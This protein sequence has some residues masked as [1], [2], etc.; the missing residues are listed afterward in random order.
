MVDSDER[1]ESDDESSGIEDLSGNK[2]TSGDE[3][4]LLDEHRNF[5]LSIDDASRMGHS[6]LG[7]WTIVAIVLVLF[8][9][10]VPIFSVWTLV[11]VPFVALAA[12]IL[13]RRVGLTSQDRRLRARVVT[14]CQELG[15]SEHDLVA[16]AKRS[17]RYEFFIKLISGVPAS[18]QPAKQ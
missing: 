11:L 8:L 16:E 13:G 17:G 1:L 14:Y 2:E 9:S 18:R 15:I 10:G 12:L 4:T 5:V 6:L 7:I 3:T